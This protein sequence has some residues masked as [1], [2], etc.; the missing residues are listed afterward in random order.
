MT[1]TFTFEGEPL[2]DE[3][4]EGIASETLA[5]LDAMSDGEASGRTRPLGSLVKRLGRPRVGGT[6]GTGPSAQV[7]VRVSGDLLDRLDARAAGSK[8]SRSEIIRD[9]LQAYLRAG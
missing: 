6:E 2:T 1:K 9:A 7:R 4:A 5:D 8:R 3:R